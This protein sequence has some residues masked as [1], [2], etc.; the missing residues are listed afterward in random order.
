MKF[1]FRKTRGCEVFTKHAPP[2][3]DARQLFLPK[4][5]VLGRIAINGLV[6]TAVDAQVG[7]PVAVQI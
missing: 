5:I 4:R 3:I 2:Q 7:L 1:V 6:R